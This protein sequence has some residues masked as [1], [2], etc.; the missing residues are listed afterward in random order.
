MTF[1]PFDDY[2]QKGYLR[3]IAGALDPDIVKRLEHR[4]VKSNIEEALRNL[5]TGKPL[6]YQDVL[7]THGTLFKDVY[8]WA[9]KDRISVGRQEAQL[10]GDDS[11][12]NIGSV[13][14]KG[15]VVFMPSSYAERGVDYALQIGNDPEK[16]RS[17]LGEV[18][19][20]LAYAN[21][22]LDGNWRTLMAVHG[23]LAARA[24]FHID[25]SQ[26]NKT[27]Y[28]TALTNEIDN[29]NSKTLD[30]YLKPFVREGALSLEERQETFVSLPGLS[31]P[32]E[33]PT[34]IVLAGPDKAGREDLIGSGEGLV[35]MDPKEQQ[36][37]LRKGL[38]FTV[39]TSLS[40]GSSTD[41]VQE[42]K[43]A[44]F[45][46]HI[47][48]VGGDGLGEGL[49]HSLEGLS[50]TMTHAD[51][52]QIFDSSGS[53]IRE[54]ADVTGNAMSFN[55]AKSWAVDAVIDGL[56]KK[57]EGTDRLNEKMQHLD[58]II[59]AANAGAENHLPIA[60]QAEAYKQKLNDLQTPERDGPSSKRTDDGHGL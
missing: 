7:K 14:S 36:E 30:T 27:D 18:M 11:K 6:T 52:V 5:Q 48:F 24:G 51:R 43:E 60:Q 33:R 45:D 2:A 39:S 41:L 25:W 47:K 10:T 13:I 28:L 44:G 16:M 40:N 1:D 26:T 29:P 9:G 8:P 46:V 22:F 34:M 17:S 59:E 42:A 3:N 38:P 20:S 55:D 37:A 12:R 56:S 4:S 23:E 21:P 31:K 53:Q 49:K 19:G 15:S 58:R 35:V 32:D 57:L 54:L 50:Q